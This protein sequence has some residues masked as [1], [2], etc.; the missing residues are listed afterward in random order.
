MPGRMKAK[1]SRR[2]DLNKNERLNVSKTRKLDNRFKG[3]DAYRVKPEP[4]PRTLYLPVKYFTSSV[5]NMLAA[6]TAN[7]F[8]FRVNSIFDPHAGA[9]GT[10]CVG[11]N[12]LAALYDRYQVLGAKIQVVFSAPSD[13]GVRV[14]VR[15]RVAAMNS[16]SGQTLKQLG[17]QPMTYISE[18]SNTGSKKKNFSFFVRPWTLMGVSKLEYLA[19]SSKYTQTMSTNPP[20]TDE[21][22]FDVFAVSKYLPAPPVSV[23]FDVKIKYYVRL[24]DRV[25]LTSIGVPI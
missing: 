8:T 6:D 7:N 9:G 4:F 5:I 23:A 22:M 21:C 12:Q 25:P 17:E 2:V 11:F 13:G 20:T 15:L 14:G 10:T 16:T 1:R 18:I 24:Y 3:I 19:N